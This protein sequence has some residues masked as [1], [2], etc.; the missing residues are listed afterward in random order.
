MSD[1]YGLAK[2][3]MQE[4]IKRQDALYDD[5]VIPSIMTDDVEHLEA[6]YRKYQESLKGFDVRAFRNVLEVITTTIKD[7]DS[8]KFSDLQE[9]FNSIP[10]YV[11]QNTN[12]TSRLDELNNSDG[13]PADKQAMWET[14]DRNRTR[15]HNACIQL[16]NNINEIATSYDIAE[17]YPND[18]NVY[19]PQN[20]LDR[21]KVANVVLQQEPL[22]DTIN[23]LML[24]Q[25]NETGVKSTTEKLRTMS[26][27]QLFNY[28]KSQ[29][30]MRDLMNDT[31]L[32]DI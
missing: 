25:V 16:F 2:A 24:E 27:G 8:Q 12:F 1:W 5:I 29:L 4:N 30:D 7:A 9:Q 21:E 32:G 19:S 18:G 3:Q 22:F 23:H 11:N 15:A 17:P 13:T 14:L 6:N 20:P 31:V 28:A 26:L 10:E